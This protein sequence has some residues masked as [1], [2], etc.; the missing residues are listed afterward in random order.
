MHM[1][2]FQQQSILKDQTSNM[3]NHTD[4]LSFWQAYHK[5]L[6]ELQQLVSLHKSVRVSLSLTES[7]RV[8]VNI[9]ESSNVIYK[10]FR[11]RNMITNKKQLNQRHQ[12][13][14]HHLQQSD[15]LIFDRYWLNPL[16]DQQT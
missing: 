14:T 9:H 7:P 16:H 5:S 2:P 10:S 11:N 6:Q 13:K 4:P 8:F 1:T 12:V 15:L 3:S